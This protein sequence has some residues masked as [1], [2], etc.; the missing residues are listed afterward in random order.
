M[1]KSVTLPDFISN[2]NDLGAISL[3]ATHF[4]DLDDKEIFLWFE[5]GWYSDDAIC[6]ND[7]FDRGL[8]TKVLEDFAKRYHVFLKENQDGELELR[9]N[10]P[11]RLLQT[12][13]AVYF[14]IDEQNFPVHS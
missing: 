1:K 14:W 2:Q 7:L 13:V 11:A 3:I 9:S 6:F 10:Y 4:I 5:D 8:S 12:I